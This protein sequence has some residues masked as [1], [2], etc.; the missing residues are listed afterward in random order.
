MVG[1][2]IA[3]IGSFLEEKDRVRERAIRSAREIVRKARDAVGRVHRR[4]V[5]GAR[6]VVEEISK[7]VKEVREVR[8]RYPDLYYSGFVQDAL[9]EYYEALVLCEY[10]QTGD[11]RGVRPPPEEY[12]PFLLGLAD[13]V[14]ELRRESLSALIEGD[15]DRARKL[16]EF[17]ESVLWELS[18]LTF[19]DALTPGLRRKVDVIRRVVEA[20]RNDLFYASKTREVLEEL[21]KLREGRRGR[22]G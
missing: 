6:V 9:A 10:A 7:L 11:V 21:E 2:L 3:E 13:A 17:M 4:D 16:L 14:G 15:L 18:K 22:S 20:T 1:D 8:E 12:V 5:E 19:P